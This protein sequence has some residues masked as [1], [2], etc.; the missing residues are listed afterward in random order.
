MPDF[1]WA[2]S[3]EVIISFLMDENGHFECSVAITCLLS[4]VLELVQKSE[5]IIGTFDVIDIVVEILG[6]ITALEIIK[7]FRRLAY[8]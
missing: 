2:Y 4:I 6:I 3:L 8:L 7:H 5:H 1:L